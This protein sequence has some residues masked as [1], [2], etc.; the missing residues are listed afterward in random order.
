RTRIQR[1]M[2]YAL[3]DLDAGLMKELL[4]C[5]P[6][7]LHVLGHD[8]KGE[9]VLAGCRDSDIPLVGNYSRIR[10]VLT[11]YYGRRTDKSRLAH[12][13]LALELRATRTY[14]LLLKKWP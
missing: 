4:D 7:Y 2:M 13:Q 6:L 9:A 8:K 3:L 10:N 14:G 1:L 5:G 12:A 11:R